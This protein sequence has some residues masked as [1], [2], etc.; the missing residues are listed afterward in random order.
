MDEADLPIDIH[1]SKLLEWLISRRHCPRTWQKNIP[2]IENLEANNYWEVTEYVKEKQY[3]ENSGRF[4]SNL[5][6]TE[7]KEWKFIQKI[8]KEYGTNNTFLA[9]TASL[10]SRLVHYEVPATKK[11]ISNLLNER[12]ENLNRISSL[13]KNLDNATESFNRTCLEF[14]IDLATSSDIHQDA[15]RQLQ[16]MA[17]KLPTYSDQITSVIISN[18]GILKELLALYKTT[19]K[20]NLLKILDNDSLLEFTV[21]DKVKT[22]IPDFFQTEI[23]STGDGIEEEIDWSAYIEEED[24]E[25]TSHP[26]TSSQKSAWDM[27][28]EALQHSET[29]TNGFV[30]IDTN[31]GDRSKLIF[32]NGSFRDIILTEIEELRSFLNSKHDFNKSTTI[33]MLSIDYDEISEENFARYI[34][35]LDEIKCAMEDENF[36]RLIKIVESPIFLDKLAKTFSS[37]KN[38]LDKYSLQM[39]QARNSS[40]SSQKQSVHLKPKLEELS[41]KCKEMKIFLEKEISKKYDGRRVNLM[42]QYNFI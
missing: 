38:L 37:K 35:A 33:A 11:Q 14:G 25:K 10:L 5:T 27:T 40:E 17:Y 34:S 28:E 36:I 19:E 30:K 41:K 20:L 16:R 4:T 1:L 23:K 31:T 24:I 9:E 39:D 32:L 21:D 42:G 7:E 2:K 15:K 3:K 22:A 18:S 13:Q 6:E 8:L 12:E 29:H 26:S